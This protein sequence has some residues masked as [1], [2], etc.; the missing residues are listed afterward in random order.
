MKGTSILVACCV[1]VGT[2][3]GYRVNKVE[4]ATAAVTESEIQPLIVGGTEVPIGQKLYQTGLRS[5][6]S[7]GSF[8]GGALITPMH[9]LSAGHC[10]GVAY[11]AVGTHY[12]SGTRDG[13]RI[14]VKKE[15]RHPKYNEPDNN[16]ASYDFLILELAAPTVNITPV[17][18]L[19][20]D[21][22][23]VM[24]QTATT[25]GWGR[26]G[27]PTGAASN[28]LLRSDGPV[29]SDAACKAAGLSPLDESMVCAGGAKNTGGCF[30]DSGGPL[31]LERPTGDVAI[32]VVSWGFPN[33]CG[34][35]SKP[36][37]FGRLA[38]VADWLKA[39]APG[40]VFA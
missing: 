3:L 13:Q 38:L 26:T 25:I 35:D 6:A 40:V 5:T 22:S 36:V 33:S 11:V 30:G 1:L 27:Y 8:C 20:A 28:V 16:T 19:T 15:T 29:A 12:R 18:V 34:L 24:G 14:R 31:I 37:V 9:V 7:G 32:G 4:A 2:A 39:N 17:A 10:S 23:T 21:P